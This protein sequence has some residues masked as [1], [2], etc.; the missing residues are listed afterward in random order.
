MPR[1]WPL[2]A[3]ADPFR[4]SEKHSEL[5]ATSGSMLW[6]CKRR[7]ASADSSQNYPTRKPFR[8]MTPPGT[9]ST[10]TLSAVIPDHRRQPEETR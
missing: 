3:K 1:P 6:R 7:P 2:P 8:G 10:P 4:P 5:G 9:E